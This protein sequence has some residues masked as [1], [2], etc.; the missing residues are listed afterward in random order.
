MIAYSWALAADDAMNF[1]KLVGAVT[2]IVTSLKA[3][4]KVR[5]L[6]WIGR[7]LITDPLS[8]WFVSTVKDATKDLADK[9]DRAAHLLEYHNGSNGTTKPIHKRISDIEEALGLPGTPQQHDESQ[10]PE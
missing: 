9:V 10:D 3:A 1:A 2:V 6:Q 8:G 4:S 7:K 5:W